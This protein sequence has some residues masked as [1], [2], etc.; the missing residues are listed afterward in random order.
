MVSRSSLASEHSA[1]NLIFVVSF[2]VRIM[3]LS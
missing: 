3:K 2:R 1:L